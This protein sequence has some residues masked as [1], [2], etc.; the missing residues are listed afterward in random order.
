MLARLAIAVAAAAMG[1]AAAATTPP[2][3]DCKVQ[4]PAAVGVGQ[5]VRLRVTF[6]NPGPAPVVLLNWGTPFEQAWFAPYLRVWHNGTELGYRGANLKRGDPDRD[7]YLRIAAGRQRTA[8]AD[9]GL[10]FDVSRSGRYRVEPQITVHDLLVAGT[11]R[12]PRPR[13]RHAAQVLP[14]A[15]VEFVIG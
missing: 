5:P 12:L 7:E 8:L 3:L 13:E 10:A 4:A 6:S 11:D 14:C 15:A 2:R 9:L 1:S